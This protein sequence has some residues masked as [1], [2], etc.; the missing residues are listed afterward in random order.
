MHGSGVFVVQMQDES[1]TFLFGG[2]SG[3]PSALVN[4]RMPRAKQ[5]Q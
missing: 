3:S 5:G 1:R 2:K 4:L